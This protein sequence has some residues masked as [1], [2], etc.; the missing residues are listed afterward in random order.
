MAEQQV[1]TIRDSG[2]TDSLL[3]ETSIQELEASLKGPLLRP[4]EIGFDD[5]RRVWNAGAA[6]AASPL[7]AVMGKGLQ[8]R[9]LRL[10]LA[11]I[12]CLGRCISSSATMAPAMP[13]TRSASK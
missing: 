7:I 9:A 3:K 8:D 5:A 6:C 2:T 13:D 1:V 12:S 4:G 11:Q 10:S